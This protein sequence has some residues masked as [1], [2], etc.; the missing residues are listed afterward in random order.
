ML[1]D[2]QASSA[3][4]AIFRQMTPERRLSLAEQLYWSARDLKAGTVRRETVISGDRCSGIRT[5][6]VSA[7]AAS[8]RISLV[9]CRTLPGQR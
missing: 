1:P 7:S 9:S 3:Q 4:L 5:A 6:P 2:E 8:R